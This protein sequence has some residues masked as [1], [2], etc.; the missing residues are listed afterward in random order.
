MLSFEI[1]HLVQ[2]SCKNNQRIISW[3]EFFQA[4]SRKESWGYITSLIKYISKHQICEMKTNVHSFLFHFRITWED[5]RSEVHHWCNSNVKQVETK[6]TKN[7]LCCFVG[8]TWVKIEH[9]G[10]DGVIILLGEVW[11]Q[12]MQ[13]LPCLQVWQRRPPPLLASASVECCLCPQPLF[14]A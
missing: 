13:P 14:P 3:D 10:C 9:K 1:R 11:A 6:S 12:Q 5:R 4:A 7:L 8:I 2:K